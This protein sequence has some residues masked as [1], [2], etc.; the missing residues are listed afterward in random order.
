MGVG[1]DAHVLAQP[2][3]ELDPAPGLVAEHVL[4]QERH[5]AKRPVA[6]RLFVQGFDPVRVGLDDGVDRGID[7]AHGG[8]GR[9]RELPGRNLSAGDESGQA[10]RVAARVFRELHD[11]RH[12]EVF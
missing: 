6:E 5:A 9:F 4:D 10:E 12:S 7:G 2:A 11:R 1:G 8:C 3:A